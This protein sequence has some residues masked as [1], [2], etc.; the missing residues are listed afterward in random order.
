MGLGDIVTKLFGKKQTQP[1]HCYQ[2]IRKNGN[3]TTK[4]PQEASKLDKDEEGNIKA[5][6]K[7]DTPLPVE[8][9]SMLT[10][11]DAIAKYLSENFP[12]CRAYEAVRE[13][14]NKTMILPYLVRE[15]NFS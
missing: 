9:G 5:I 12:E 4:N 2:L 15:L 1:S 8:Y 13:Y 10:E 7:C 6:L 3:F 11:K 14:S